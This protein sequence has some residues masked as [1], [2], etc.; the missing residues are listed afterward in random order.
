MSKIEISR[1]T[2][3]A[4]YN[5]RKHDL[6]GINEN[7]EVNND[8]V[9]FQDFREVESLA[10]ELALPITFFFEKKAGNDLNKGIAIERS[11]GAFERKSY[12]KEKLYYTYRHLAKTSTVPSLMALHVTLHCS[13]KADME[14]NGGHPDR[15]II[16]VTKGSVLMNWKEN[17][18]NEAVLNEGD[19][20][21]VHPGVP[22]SFI[23]NGSETAE[24]IAVNF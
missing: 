24:I 16:Y 15:E 10:K 5:C 22:H 17:E 6:K 23:S 9:L 2:V 14:L 12:R 20:V 18:I 7:Y 11:Q 13:D 19:S 3:E 4:A 1:S 21:Y 8:S